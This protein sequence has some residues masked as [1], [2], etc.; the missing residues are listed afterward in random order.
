VELTN[1]SL[2]TIVDAVKTKKISS[3]EVTKHFLERIRSL[4]SKLNS[5]ISINDKALDEAKAV[6]ELIGKGQDP[7]VLAGVPVA[8]KDLL[9]TQGLR[10]TAA[11]KVLENFIPPY[12]ATVVTRLKS[13][14]AVV[15]GKTSLDEFA[16]GSS[17]ETSAFGV[18]K[19]PW[20]T[21]FVPGGSSGGS[22][23]ALAA[24]LAPVAIGT[25]TG[26][27]IRQP[28]SFCGVY[29]IKPTYGRVSRYGI[30]AYASSLDQ[31]GPMGNSTADCSLLLE[32]MSGKCRYDA[33]TA[34]VAV[35]QWTRE[36]K[37]DLKGVRIGLPKEYFAEKL[38]SDVERITQTAIEAL[39]SRG[40]TMTEVSLPLVKHSVSMYY[41]IATSEASSNLARYDG[42]RYGYRSD[43][44]KNPAGNLEE[45]YSR[46]R[47]EAFGTEVKRRIML[48]TYALSSGYYDAYYLKA[49]RVRRLLR[50][51]YL[52]ALETC[53]LL[54][55]P[56]ATSPAFKIGSRISDPLAMYLNDIFTTSTNL[57]GLPGMSVPGGFSKDGLPIGVQLTA[58]HFDEQSI[59]NAS[60]SL[61]KTL[62]IEARQ[63]HVI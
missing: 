1:A 21:D 4:D 43:Y 26:G 15:L 11:S 41:L 13:A 2:V 63:P 25:D 30:I 54:L 37:E 40:A 23:A 18:V 42:V 16:M 47:G 10:T 48:G 57:A 24:R 14:G 34:S 35:P 44:S 6:D 49:C 51:Q 59:F 7:G 60:Y 3:V 52:K 62:K 31:A 20:N 46:N 29:G 12:S 61:E 22:A 28:A 38:D 36:L 9:C 45:F 8:I 39:K 32:V 50:D 19:N 5:F 55:S 33:T 27:S 56:V 58:R 53:D 17:N